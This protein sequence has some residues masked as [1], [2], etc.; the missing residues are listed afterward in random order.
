MRG[1]DQSNQ[2]CDPDRAQ[3]GNLLE[4][5][6]GGMFPALCYQFPSCVLPYPQQTVEL[7][8]ELFGAPTHACFTEFVQPHSAVTRRVDLLTAKV[9]PVVKTILCPQ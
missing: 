6:T 4:Q 7:P 8:V 9:D 2:E 3:P 1:L 5:R